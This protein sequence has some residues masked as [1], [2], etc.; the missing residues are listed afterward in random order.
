MAVTEV[1]GPEWYEKQEMDWSGDPEESIVSTSRKGTPSC[2]SV[3]DA[4]HEKAVDSASNITENEQEQEG[5]SGEAPAKQEEGT[6]EFYY[7]VAHT[8]QD[9][10]QQSK[11]LFH[12][13]VLAADSGD[14]STLAGYIELVAPRAEEVEAYESSEE[15]E[16][17]CPA[18]ESSL[19]E[20]TNVSAQS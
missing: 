2:L 9:G 6:N 12:Q 7:I 10:I 4:L 20:S 15:D 14:S 18:F 16:V 13:L 5:E 19:P 17:D 8:Y 11:S 1:F 3:S